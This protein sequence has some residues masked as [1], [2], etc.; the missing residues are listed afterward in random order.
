MG[1]FGAPAGGTPLLPQHPQMMMHNQMMQQQMMD[2]QQMMQQQRMMQQARQKQLMQQQMRMMQH[3]MNANHPQ[4][5]HEGFGHVPRF[6]GQPGW[7]QG[8]GGEPFRYENGIPFDE[9]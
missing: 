8:Y 7:W 6:F 2:H 1:L 3:C 9:A 4:I 5:P